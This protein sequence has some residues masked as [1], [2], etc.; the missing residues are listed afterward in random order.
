MFQKKTHR[1]KDARW[2]M[3]I[4][5]TMRY[6][7][8][9]IRVATIKTNKQTNRKTSVGEDVGKLEPLWPAGGNVK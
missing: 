8:T 3:P 1:G 7:L 4:K 5:I 2:G 6:H 9:S